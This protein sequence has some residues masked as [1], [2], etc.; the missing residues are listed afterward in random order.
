MMISCLPSADRRPQH[1]LQPQMLRPLYL[2]FAL[3]SQTVNQTSTCIAI[4]HR[5]LVTSTA[6]RMGI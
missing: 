4:R 2:P 1:N 3:R 6:G 5:G